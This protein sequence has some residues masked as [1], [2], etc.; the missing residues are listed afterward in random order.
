MVA[1]HTMRFGQKV[2]G[3]FRFCQVQDRVQTCDGQKIAFRDKLNQYLDSRW[4][5]KNSW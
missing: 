5:D 4:E 2:C 1:L 3:I